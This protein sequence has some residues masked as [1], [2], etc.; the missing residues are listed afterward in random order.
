M[1]VHVRSFVASHIVWQV[2]PL[3]SRQT[4]LGGCPDI[5][6][7][8]PAKVETPLR[9]SLL[10]RFDV[11]ARPGYLRMVWIVLSHVS[12]PAAARRVCVC[13]DD[14]G[15]EVAVAGWKVF[16]NIAYIPSVAAFV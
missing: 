10:Y 3:I 15:C 6:C 5:C 13:L 1:Y 12:R 7:S 16:A 11:L 4:V 2:F 8:A 14:W 9:L